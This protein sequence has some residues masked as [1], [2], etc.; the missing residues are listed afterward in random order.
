M[1]IGICAWLPSSSS[2]G[3]GGGGEGGRGEWRVPVVVGYGHRAR[4]RAF[5]QACRVGPK[6]SRTRARERG[7]MS[8]RAGGWAP[9]IHLLIWD[10]RR[11]VSDA[12]TRCLYAAGL[13]GQSSL[14]QC[15]APCHFRVALVALPISRWKGA[16][17]ATFLP[18]EACPMHYA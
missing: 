10:Q 13:A 7:K 9:G 2:G 16:L 15:L 11:W 8:G 6:V 3:G 4:R 12:T 17:A 14:W 18:L 1:E 5:V